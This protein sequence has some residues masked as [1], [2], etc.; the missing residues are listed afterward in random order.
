MGVRM[1]IGMKLWLNKAANI[2]L[3]LTY[4][5]KFFKKTHNDGGACYEN[6]ENIQNKIH[7]ETHSFHE[8]NACVLRIS[9][10]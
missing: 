1:R 3:P 7:N 4:K 2:L 5:K 9:V 6:V 10:V 8:N